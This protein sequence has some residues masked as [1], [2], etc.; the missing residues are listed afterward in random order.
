MNRNWL[1]P[2]YDS[3]G[4]RVIPIP[5]TKSIVF[6]DIDGVIC[7]YCGDTRWHHNLK[8]LAEYLKNKYKDDIYL[9][10]PEPD[11]G[12]AFYDWDLEAIGKLKTI[13]DETDSEVVIHSDLRIW[14]NLE[15]FKGLFKLH[16]MDEYVIDVCG[17]RLDKVKTVEEYLEKTDN[18]EN[19][20]ILDDNDELAVF[21]GHFVLTYDKL[22][23]N[24]V[25]EACKILLRY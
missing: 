18:I 2:N 16:G 20:V 7:P 19:Y 22:N 17:P 3:N 21:N 23:D 12:G 11:L 25:E 10:I 15:Y 5:D 13:L 24:N 6:L 14:N 9:K 4:K 1:F 8:E